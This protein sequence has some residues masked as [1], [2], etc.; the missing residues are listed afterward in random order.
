MS[1]IVTPGQLKQRGE[2]YMQL[3]QMTSAGVSITHGVEMMR[4]SGPSARFKHIAERL[5]QYLERGA[6]FT[7]SLR[8]TSKSIPEFD[9]ALIEAGEASG[10]LDQCFRILGEYYKERG[11]LASRVL[12]QLMYPVFLF[13]FAVFLFPVSLFTDMVLK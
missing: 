5:G 12:S 6:T 8:A 4:K 10:R 13:H 1:I 9:I 2:F 3:A 7:E 11:S